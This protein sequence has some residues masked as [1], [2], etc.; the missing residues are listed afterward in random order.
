MRNDEGKATLRA[1][2]GKFWPNS[3]GKERTSERKATAKRRGP[4]LFTA[5][6][7]Q[8]ENFIVILR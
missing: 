2:V 7:N 3:P 1:F 5:W 8:T 4:N 6:P